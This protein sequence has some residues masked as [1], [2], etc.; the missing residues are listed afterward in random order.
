MC[1]CRTQATKPPK[2]LQG[3]QLQNRGQRP[4][5]PSPHLSEPGDNP[6]LF[7]LLPQQLRMTNRS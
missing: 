2:L 5:L 6:N 1:T 7:L 3:H 4:R